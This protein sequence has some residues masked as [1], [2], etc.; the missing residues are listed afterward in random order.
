MQQPDRRVTSLS[1]RVFIAE[2]TDPASFRAWLRPECEHALLTGEATVAGHRVALVVGDFDVRG[3]SIGLTEAQ[4]FTAALRRATRDRLPVV[5]A[6]ASG[7][8]RMQDGTPAFVQMVPMA[9]A[10]LDHQRAGLPYVVYL[11]HPTTGGVMASWGALGHLTF[12]EPGALLGFLGPR[13]VEALSGDTIPRQVQSAE[14]LFSHGL[15]DGVLDVSQLRATLTGVLKVLATRGRG[16]DLSP[17]DSSQPATALDPWTVV[18]ASRDPGRDGVRELLACAD[19]VTRIPVAG[20]DAPAT[21]VVVALARLNHQ[22]CVVLGQDRASQLAGHLIGP[23]DLRLARRA[24]RLAGEFRLPLVS[25]VDTSGAELSA[26]A[27][28]GGLAGE[29]AGCIAD[30]LQLDTPTVSVLMGQG[31]GGA[32]LALL[33][34]DSVIACSGAWLAPLPPEGASAIMHRSTAY[35]ATLARSQRIGADELHRLGFV[36]RVVSE[37]VD[38]ATGRGWCQRLAE[39]VGSELA[40]LAATDGDRPRRASR[41]RL[42]PPVGPGPD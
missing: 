22:S 2:L 3:G 12:G 4:E 24:I 39:A 31:G 16:L 26:E 34:A 13:A 40:R 37:D 9:S 25:V 11:R 21:G 41:F 7:G 6:P 15:L 19:H 17:P 5:A 1:A 33:P 38:P 10:V 29:I 8:T 42:D 18:Q 35:A 27:E 14:N 28:E 20:R 32:A 36:D 30:L 23:A